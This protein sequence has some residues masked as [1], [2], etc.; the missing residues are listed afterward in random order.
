MLDFY[1][2]PSGGIVPIVTSLFL[3]ISKFEH[4]EN[5]GGIIYRNIGV[6]LW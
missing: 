4:I 3:H 6:Q 5:M 1:K 2:K